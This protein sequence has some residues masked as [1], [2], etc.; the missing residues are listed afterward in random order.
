VATAYL[1]YLY[2]PEAQKIIAENYYRPIDPSV[3]RAYAAKF[4][5]LQLFTVDR[6]FGGWARTQAAHFADGAAFDQIFAAA[7]H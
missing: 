5:R 2:T 6:N 1:K 4:P 3:A 7:K